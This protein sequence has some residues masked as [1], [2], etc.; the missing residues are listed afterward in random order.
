METKL[1]SSRLVERTFMTELEFLQFQRD[2]KSKS[3]VEIT[4][5]HRPRAGY[6][7]F[8]CKVLLRVPDDYDYFYSRIAELEAIEE[9]KKNIPVEDLPF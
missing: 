2:E 5:F 9:A 7:S 1:D 3:T 6:E 4:S 8:Y